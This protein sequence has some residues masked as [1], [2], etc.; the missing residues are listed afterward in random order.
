MSPSSSQPPSELPAI[1]RSASIIALGNVA[2]RV[3]GLVRETVKAH[4][5]GA[6]RQVDALNVALIL[7]IQI[8]ELVTG[9]IVNSALVPVFSDYTAPERRAELWQVASTLLTLGALVLAVLLGVLEFFTPLAARVVSGGLDAPTLELTAALL[10]ITLPAVLF[11][12]LSG[13]VSGLLYSLRR[14]AL[15]A[16]TAAVFNASMVVCSLALAPRWGVR[17]MAAGLF[18]GA[19]MQ[20]AVQFPALRDA[21]FRPSFN[22]NHP[23]LRRIFRLYLPII[24]GLVITQA[25]IYIGLNL[26]SRTGEGGIAWM[27]YA[28]Y[29]YQFP[30]GLVATALSFAILPTLSRFA[31]EGTAREK[32]ANRS[33]DDFKNTLVQ[34]LNLVII[35]IVPATVGLFTLARPI[36]ALLYERGQFTAADTAQT[37]LVLQVFLLGL[38][39]AAVDQMLIFAFYA[40]KDTFTPSMVGVVS[41][42]VY[43]IAALA[44]IKPFGLFSLM[45]A[46]SLKQTTHAIVTGFLLSRR[47]GGFWRTSLI[48]TVFKTLA[49]SAL[50]GLA[51]ALA[52]TLIGR[53]SLPPGFLARALAV[54]LPAALSFAVYIATLSRL[55]VPE[56]QLLL[57]SIANRLSRIAYRD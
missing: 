56:F 5:F 11:L 57:S 46:D 28:T 53:L 10:R 1:A 31:V 17:G 32:R 30:L 16:F 26:A 4:L 21:R 43:L 51:A 41:V 22:F 6:S 36:V 44:L 8:Y 48:P 15:P 37:A 23:G 3:L 9:G 13:I 24:F 27:G 55:R 33:H 49:A 7:P 38:S 20:L 19:V 54:L 25:S 40:R 2:S 35:L 14:F 18:V 34:G 47:I 12:S 50:T 39:F 29:I 42:A 52:L 45:I